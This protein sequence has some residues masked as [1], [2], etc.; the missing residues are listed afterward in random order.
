MRDELNLFKR[1][2]SLCYLQ[3]KERDFIPLRVGYFLAKKNK[4]K[5]RADFKTVALFSNN[6]NKHDKKREV[7]LGRNARL[8]TKS[9]PEVVLCF[10][11]NEFWTGFFPLGYFIEIA[12]LI[13]KENEK[14]SIIFLSKR[15]DKDVLGLIF[16]ENLVDCL[17]DDFY[18]G[19]IDLVESFF[20][21]KR[22]EGIFYKEDFQAESF[23]VPNN[24]SKK[25]H[26]KGVK[27]D[28]KVFLDAQY[29]SPYLSGILRPQLTAVKKD[30]RKKFSC[31]IFSSWGCKFGCHF[32]LRSLRA[33]KIDFFSPQRFFDEIEYL[34]SLGFFN[35]FVADDVFSLE[36]TRLKSLVLEFEKRKAKNASLAGVSFYVMTRMEEFKSE[37]IVRLLRKMQ[38]SRVQIGLQTINPKLD[39]L[40][41]REAGE[42]DKLVKIKQWM[43]RYGIKMNLDIILGL[44]GDTIVYAK[45]TL[46][47]ALSLGPAHLQIKQLYLNPATLL[48][49]QRDEYGIKTEKINEDDLGVVFVESANGEVGENYFK[50]VARYYLKKLEFAEKVTYRITTKDLTRT[51]FN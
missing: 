31:P 5:K 6:S 3:P 51:K 12:K 38:V 11:D 40:M 50:E 28:K 33:K 30:A 48:A 16:A 14:I 9:K 20:G 10:L 43:D 41:K 24:Y 2:V 15:K 26:S 39:F 34:N 22:L 35:F 47:F 1:K 45:K 17:V 8:I 19:E 7:E 29:P 27:C 37:A 32:C 13:K 23:G 25:Q 21:K 4:T 18:L 36:K 42:T 49:R 46:D 44:P